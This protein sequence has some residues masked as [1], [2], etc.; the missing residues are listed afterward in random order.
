[1]ASLHSD[2]KLS[3]KTKT[4][5]FFLKMKMKLTIVPTANSSG[6]LPLYKLLTSHFGVLFD[7]INDA[8]L[9]QHFE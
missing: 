3:G 8:E 6:S 9:L 1:V 7:K 5:Y 4:K 2:I